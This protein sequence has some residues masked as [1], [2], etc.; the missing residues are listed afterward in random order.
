MT[1]FGKHYLA[2][3]KKDWQA[4]VLSEHFSNA[5][6]NLDHTEIEP[7]WENFKSLVRQIK[8]GVDWDKIPAHQKENMIPLLEQP[9]ARLRILRQNKVPV[10]YA[11]IAEP[12][13]VFSKF[14]EVSSA[15][16]TIEIH[17]LALFDGHR[18]KGL[19]KPFFE[20]MFKDL[21]EKYDTVVWG[22][23]DFNAPTLVQFYTDKLK[24]K[25]LGY[26]APDKPKVA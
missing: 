1:D 13:A 21:F 15:S 8:T 16:K 6:P 3:T 17:N 11:L 18:G 19:G 25:V 12:S 14:N 26:Q 7:T 5:W 9:N 22:T 20:M 4:G 10:G 23:S 24:M 2:I